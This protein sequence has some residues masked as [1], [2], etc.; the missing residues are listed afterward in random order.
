MSSALQEK[1]PVLYNMKLHIFLL[2]GHLSGWIQNTAKKVGKKLSSAKA[3]GADP[4]KYF[5]RIRL[6]GSVNPN[7]GTGFFPTIFAAFYTSFC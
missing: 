5:F 1:H 4:S 6:R 2:M 7:Y 3:S